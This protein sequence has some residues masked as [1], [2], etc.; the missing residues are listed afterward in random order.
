M[1]NR[2][3]EKERESEFLVRSELA[4]GEELRRQKTLY[5]T[6]NEG[7]VRKHEPPLF[8]CTVHSFSLFFWRSLF[9]FC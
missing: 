4:R 5:T 2:E 1:K 9:R 6:G 7:E 3:K 8:Y